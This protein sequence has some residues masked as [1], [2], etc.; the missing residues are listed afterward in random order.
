MAYETAISL[1]Q[2]ALVFCPTLQTKHLRL[3]KAF[4]QGAR[5]PSSSEY[6]SY[7]IENGHVKQAVETLRQG[8]TLIW[9][10]MRGLRTSTDQLRAAD[11]A[12]ADKLADINQRLESVVMSVVQSDDNMGHGETETGSRGCSIGNL[13]LTQRRLLEERKSLISHIQ[14][15]P[16][17]EHFLKPPSFDFLKCVTSHGPF[18][19]VNQTQAGVSEAVSARVPSHIVLLLKNA[20]PFIIS[21]PSNFRDRANQLEND[22]L[23]VRKEKGLDS[24]DYGRTL[25]SVL[26]DLY[27]L[28]G[29]P[30]IERLCKLKVPEK[31]R[32]WWCPTGT[33]C[34][35]PLHA[36]G[37]IPSDNGKKLYFSDLYI[38][39]YTPSSDLLARL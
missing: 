6:A 11:P 1:L 15:L 34:S 9:S 21:T 26:A 14:S 2:E 22:L 23:R 29:K 20:R 7:L 8:R 17:F 37:P 32:V 13:V 35:L 27:E 24:E 10:E 12:L 39:S 19:I 38:P 18:I 33:F 16:G 36:M 25:A 3:A 28:V 30:V 31:S 4:N 5:W